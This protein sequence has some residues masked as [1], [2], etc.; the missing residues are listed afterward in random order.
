MAKFVKEGSTILNIGAH[1]GLEA[2]VLG[3]GAGP[4]GRVFLFEPIPPTHQML[5]KNVYLNDMDSYTTVYQ[6]GAS[7]SYSTGI[8]H[9]GDGN[10]GGAFMNTDPNFK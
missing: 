9:V 2:I 5:V 3:R 1:I 10:T 6:M 4:K 8:S 7:D